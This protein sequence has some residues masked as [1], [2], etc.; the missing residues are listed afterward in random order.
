MSTPKISAQQ[1]R[2]I[3]VMLKNWTGKLT[4]EA[5]V[6]RVDLQLGLQTTRQ[7]LFSYTGISA[8]YKDRKAQ[9]RGA[10]PALYTKMTA[11][12]VKLVERIDHL[13]AENEILK[14]NN[15]EQLRMIERMLANARCIPNLDL[16]DLIQ[17]RPEENPKA[18]PRRVK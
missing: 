16:K 17:K 12:Q 11:S 14:R 4:W 18:G 9:F 8:C 2:Q 1:Q 15:A 3:E 13:S 5:L 7:T 6:S 10:T